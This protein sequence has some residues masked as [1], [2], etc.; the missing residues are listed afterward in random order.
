MP[1]T[2]SIARRTGTPQPRSGDQAV[3]TPD[4]ANARDFGPFTLVRVLAE[5]GLGIVFSA[6]HRVTARQ[7]ALKTVSPDYRERFKLTAEQVT[8][9]FFNEARVMAALDHPSLLPL[10]DAGHVA[11]T[12]QTSIPYLAMRLVAGGDLWG[13]VQSRGPVAEREA[14]RM[15]HD[16]ALG[17]QAMHEAGW[18]HADIKPANLLLEVDGRVRI[19]DFGNAQQLGSLPPPGAIAGTPSYLAPEQIDGR[20]LREAIDLY[21]LGATMHFAL[22]GRPPYQAG[23]VSDTIIAI[24]SAQHPPDPRELIPDLGQEVAA[25]V[26]RA[27][28]PNPDGRYGSAKQ[29]VHDCQCVLNGQAPAYAVDFAGRRRSGI[30][31]S[32]FT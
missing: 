24:R 29:L 22:T 28:H 9:L 8:Q 16:A 2:A 21:A 11:P 19:S 6:V 12:G 25:I 31:R 14:L 1:N 10:Y 5:G 18:V 32:L 13:R 20:A 7:V 17:L 15:V 23:S 27:M 3:V 30:F 26:M 4:R